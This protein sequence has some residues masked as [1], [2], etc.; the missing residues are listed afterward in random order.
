MVV[1]RGALLE[2]VRPM[3]PIERA[4]A[5]VIVDGLPEVLLGGGEHSFRIIFD[6]KDYKN[7]HEFDARVLDAAG[8]YVPV[9][10]ER[11]G[12]KMRVHVSFPP[13]ATEGVCDVVVEGMPPDPQRDSFVARFW[14]VR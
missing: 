5:D 14:F 4:R 2:T 13:E 12:T 3:R 11:W 9:R 10:I 8:A 1:R 6:P 7:C